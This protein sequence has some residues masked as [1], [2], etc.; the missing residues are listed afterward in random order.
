M[1]DKFTHLGGRNAESISGRS[2]V[3]GCHDRH[4]SRGSAA[5]E[6]AAP[7]LTS[8]GNNPLYLATADLTGDGLND[9]VSAS[10]DDGVLRVFIN[11]KLSPGTFNT[12][13]VLASPGASPC[14]PM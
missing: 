12:P 8:D 13:L 3:V 1:P 4:R 2:D 9:V 11:D 6:F 5:G 10:A 7:T 14:L